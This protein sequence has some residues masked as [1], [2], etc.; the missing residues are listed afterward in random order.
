[1]LTRRAK[2]WRV[3]AGLFTVINV[4]GAG[5]AVLSG[6]PLHAAVHVGLVVATYLVWRRL[7]R[8][9]EPDLDVHPAYERLDHLQES[10]DAIAFEVERVSEAQRYLVKIAAERARS[11]PPKA[12]STEEI[13]GRLTIAPESRSAPDRDG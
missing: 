8:A 2:V 13:A 4:G 9:Q 7:A 6:E 10:L 11:S 5:V 3:I 12:S 1:L